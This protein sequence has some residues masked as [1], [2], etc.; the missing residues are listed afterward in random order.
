MVLVVLVWRVAGKQE[1]SCLCSVP[2][3]TAK[4]GIEDEGCTRCAVSEESG[5]RISERN[6]HLT[7]LT[8]R[9]SNPELINS[10]NLF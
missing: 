2:A 7:T 6:F 4:D 1:R 10:F 8:M 5:M 9:E 3:E